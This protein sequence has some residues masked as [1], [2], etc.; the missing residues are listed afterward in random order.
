MLNMSIEMF[1]VEMDEL[2]EMRKKLVEQQ[3]KIECWEI[4]EAGP[5]LI[6]NPKRFLNFAKYKGL[7]V[8]Q[9]E[10]PEKDLRYRL[11]ILYKETKIMSYATEKEFEQ[12]KKEGK[13]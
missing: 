12:L 10:V 5:V 11:S 9:E 6:Y 7:P 13:I 8:K 2:L 4:E 3:K 1:S